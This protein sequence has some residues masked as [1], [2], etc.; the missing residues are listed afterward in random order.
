MLGFI[1]QYASLFAGR[2]LKTNASICIFKKVEINVIEKINTT[3]I[4]VLLFFGMFIMLIIVTVITIIYYCI[5]KNTP[6]NRPRVG[7]AL[8]AAVMGKVSYS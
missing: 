6:K 3:V 1:L 8:I 5:K 7:P 4:I 2:T